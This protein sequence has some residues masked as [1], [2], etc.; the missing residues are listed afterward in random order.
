[1]S[2][3]AEV[4]VSLG[5]SVTGSDVAS[6]GNTEKLSALGVKI[7]IGHRSENVSGATIVVYS[8]AIRNTNVEII[9]AREAG[10]PIMKRAEMLAEL[11]RL[12]KGIA[13]AGTHGKTTTT[14]FLATIL[15]EAGH[16]PTYLIGGIVKNLGGHAKVGN[17]EYV[18]VEADE[19]DGSFLLL[20]PVM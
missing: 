5:F 9:A 1:M 11:M 15:E 7:Q 8:S 17:G 2:G 4:L 18:L 13:I 3:I 10:V 6:S 19:S 14:S 16:D 12:K 20:N